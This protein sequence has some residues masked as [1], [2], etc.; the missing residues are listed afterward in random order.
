MIDV[1]L[2]DEALRAAGIPIVSVRNRLAAI[3][4]QY[5]PEATE[6]QRA[7]GDALVAAWDAAAE[8]K[9]DR[10]R[11][12][13]AALAG[14]DDPTQIAIRNALRVIYASIV[15][16]RQAHNALRAYVANPSGTPPP[17]LAIRKWAQALAAVRQQIDA[18]ID[19]EG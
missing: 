3:T 10:R 14:A 11:R 13:K 4:V 12:A 8:S 17:A 16:T 2:I 18:E 9:A 5:A 19:P 1:G 7:A 15:E 6:Q